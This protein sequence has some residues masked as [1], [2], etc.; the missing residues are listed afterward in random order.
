[1]NIDANN[2]YIIVPLMEEKILRLE[3]SVMKSQKGMC[4]EMYLGQSVFFLWTYVEADKA[5]VSKPKISIC[6]QI[7]NKKTVNSQCT[8]V[9]V[10]N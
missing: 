7:K 6:Y 3:H 5:R 2:K 4:N 1:L 9:Y 10:L 8:D